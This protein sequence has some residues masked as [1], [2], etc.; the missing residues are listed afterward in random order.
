MEK[1]K[2]LDSHVFICSSNICNICVKN[3]RMQRC[4]FHPGCLLEKD[5]SL[6]RNVP[7]FSVM[8]CTVPMSWTRFGD[9]LLNI[10]NRSRV[11]PV[12]YKCLLHKT[13][14]GHSGTPRLEKSAPSG[15]KR[16]RASYR[17]SSAQRKNPVWIRFP[18]QARFLDLGPWCEEALIICGSVE[19]NLKSLYQALFQIK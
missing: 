16:E 17:L 11:C 12:F 18:F 19:E 4:T 15:R 13:T 5:V 3:Q 10:L 8:W 1:L 2:L 6:P 14:F 9:D 7:S